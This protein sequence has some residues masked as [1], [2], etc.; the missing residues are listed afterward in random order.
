MFDTAFV[1][2]VIAVL[3]V[4]VGLCQPLAAYLKLPPPA[5]LGVIGVALGGFPVLM[6]KLGWSGSADVFA[7]AFAALPV[8]SA[9]FIYVFLPLLVFEA[10]IATD[11]RRVIED[12]APILLLAI[13]ATLVTTAV[14]G[15]ALWQLAGVP[16]V[17]CLLLGP[18]VATT[19]PAAV[20]AIFRGV[21]APGR[22]TRLVEGEALLND[23]AA[24]ALFAVLLG[25][26][27]AAREPN[28]GVGLSEFFLSFVGGGLLGLIAGRALLWVIPW[29]REDRL[30]EGTLTLALA[31]GVFIAADRLFHVSGVVAALGSGLTVS[32]LGRSRIAPNNWS[33]LADLWDQ[34]AFWARSLVFVLAS[35]LVPRLLG[36]IDLH[37][38]GLLA[39]LVTA[40]FV[41]R[42]LVLF[43]L[44]PP[45]EYLKLTQPISAAYKLAM[46]WGGLRGALT[47]VLALAVTENR[48]LDPQ[49]Q[50]FVAVL[51]TG[52]VLF[53]LF[54]NGTTLRLVIAFLGL[55][56][57][58]PRNEV[59]RD[60]VLALSYAEVCDA[61]RRLAEAHALAPAAVQQ[62]IEPYEAWI[63]AANARDSAERL[64]E[65][66]RL[67]IAL[68]AL[69]NQE[70]AVAL[71]TRAARIAPPATVQTLLHNADTLLD[72]ARTEGRLGYR[73]A[74]DAILSFPAAFRIAY[75]LYR[76]F[77]IRRWLA[78]RLADRVEMLLVTKLLV[79]RLIDFNNE[80]LRPIF[81]ERIS[82]LTGEIMERRRG[83]LGSA[84]D[85]LQR[86]Y[87]DY[88]AALEVRFLRQS[89]VRQETG[90]YQALFQEGFIPQELF[91]D[92][93]R[94]VAA[95]R[96]GEPRPRFDM[97]LD[98]RRLIEQLDFLS[99]L[100][101]AQLDRVA[102]LLRP[103]FTVPNERVVRAGDRGDAVF[104]IASGAVE[105]RL[106]VRHVRLGTG[107]FFG[108]MALL[109]G[110]PR[111]AD[112]VA[113]SYC[114]LLVLRK[115]DFDRFVTANPDAGAV[116]NRVAEA[117][118]AMNQDDHDRAAEVA[119]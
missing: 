65:R 116:I 48:A 82:E 93:K 52:L 1:L 56:R 7:D 28:I 78:D 90:R 9:T 112:V 44:M 61:V 77:G 22:L 19:D 117:R 103:R 84:L 57:L 63:T 6:S 30:A 39:V 102:K 91:E 27:V 98:T 105:V 13:I 64:T 46:A 51:A 16:L 15:L 115:A 92:L 94:G 81:G 118:L 31:Y 96:A 109:T 101:N 26:I 8:S 41:A 114:R 113:L 106:P 72:G 111:Q 55:D 10:G 86:Q 49:V 69:A 11:V 33:F 88:V 34:I 43:V 108:E 73:R 24:I 58:S 76:H 25:M 4:A 35:I 50:R 60:R 29:L 32:A 36:H 71:E 74:A 68:V 97:G 119:S 62:I 38:L 23:A 85:A 40:A 80:R 2:L 66:D 83:D 53:T 99:A 14:I 42:I 107:E 87:P 17:V 70:R 45:L 54:V 3:L 47:L 20:I 67:A 89:A 75:S 12:A 95:T 100:S 21:G 79:D 5:L 37:D 18:V 110:R 59:L 104:F